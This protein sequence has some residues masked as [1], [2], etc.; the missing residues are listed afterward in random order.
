MEALKQEIDEWHDTIREMEI[1]L[2]DTIHE[3]ILDREELNKCMLEGRI[4][5]ENELLEV[6]TRR[7]E[8]ER[9]ELL[10]IARL[11]MDTLNHELEMLDEQLEA[12]KRLN[13]EEDREEALAELEEQLAR[14]SADP[15]RKR[16]NLHFGK[17]LLSCVKKLRGIWQKKK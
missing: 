10:E 14:I 8:K 7:Y 9:D 17:R 13:E 1:D 6:L 5:L 11:K 12:R 15:T 2:R 16:K 4:D 3:A